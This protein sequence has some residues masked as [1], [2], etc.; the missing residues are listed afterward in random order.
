MI[1]EEKTI[2]FEE[3]SR[4]KFNNLGLAIGMTLKF[5]ISVAKEL[6]RKVRK[7]SELITTFVKGTGEKHV[8]GGIG[9]RDFY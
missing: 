9:L 7:F 5:C 6:K 2:F 3:C 1:W 8:R 4:F